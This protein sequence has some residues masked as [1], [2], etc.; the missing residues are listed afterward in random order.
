MNESQH[1][2]LYR[3]RLKEQLRDAKMAQAQHPNDF[4]HAH[5]VRELQLLLHTCD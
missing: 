3:T 2:P 1:H 5:K 4:R